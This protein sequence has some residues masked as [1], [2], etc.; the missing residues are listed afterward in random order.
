MFLTAH[1]VNLSREIKPKKTF[2]F[3]Q[4]VDWQ[5]NITRTNC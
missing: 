2:A 3:R 1:P 5:E 4:S